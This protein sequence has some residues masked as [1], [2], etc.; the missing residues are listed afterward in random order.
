MTP[1]AFDTT[2]H[3]YI[4]W[5]KFEGRL[6][7]LGFGA[8]GQGVLPLLLRHHLADH[9]RRAGWPRLGHAPSPGGPGRSG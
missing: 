1:M 5:A 4:K 8:I 3:R 7:M 9:R 2:N 6:L